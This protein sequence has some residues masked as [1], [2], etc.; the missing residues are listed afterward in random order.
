MLSRHKRAH[1]SQRDD[2]SQKYQRSSPPRTVSA[3]SDRNES[4]DITIGRFDQPDSYD[5]MSQMDD[6]TVQNSVETPVL[7]QS[8][9]WIDSGDM[10]EFLMSDLNWP[11]TLP[12]MQF[13]PSDLQQGFSS[14]VLHPLPSQ[15]TGPGHHAMQQMSKLISDLSSSLT[16]EIESTGITSAFLDT[17]MHV[18]FERFIPSFPVLHK[19]TFSVR[20][21]SHPLLLN[22]IALGSLFVGAKD[23]LAK[24]E[25]LWRL[26]HTAVA[27]SWQ[28]LMATKGPRDSCNGIQLVLT[29]LLGQT[30]AILS[31]N[32]S[33][34]MTSQVFHGLGFYWARQCGM[35]DI[36]E[37]RPSDLPAL[38]ATESQK[39]AAWKTWAAREIQRRA[40]LGHYILDGQIS[41]FSGHSTCA[42]HVINPLLTPA[43]GTAFGA[44]TANAW[45]ME[46][47]KQE[48]TRPCFRE[49]FVSLFSSASPS[50]ERSLS[51]FSLR[52]VLEG[53]QSL[54][55]DVQ[56]VDGPA[57]GTPSK[58]VVARALVRLHN[59]RLSQSD[60]A[61][62]NME[63]LVRWH[64]ICLNLAT[65]TTP[66]CQ[67]LCQFY[68]VQQQLHQLSK[69][70]SSAFDF[71]AWSKSVDGLR[72]LLHAMAIQDL[73]ER[74]PLGRSHAI[75]LPAAIF[76]V[77]TIYSARCIAG[78]PTIIIPKSFRWQDV[79]AID[80][81]DVAN[82][83][84]FRDGDIN[85]FLRNNS[86]SISGETST[87][88]LM[89]DLN[90][91][92]ITLSSISLRWGVSHAMDDVLHRWITIANE[93]GQSNT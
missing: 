42:R 19:A 40:I 10:L 2:E 28:A 76:S 52:V 25:A 26:A 93:T 92:Q 22:I 45:I 72:A 81:S 63:L 68:G 16:A 43:S 3:D 37:F 36:E 15:Q 85:A 41:Q 59:E 91:L 75:H 48:V 60:A 78:F 80:M 51:N 79:W 87:R 70:S 23:A 53:L 1:E 67:N 24:G 47:Q 84:G 58:G 21:S 66:L 88:N 17:C 13:Q 44:K 73:V 8:Q 27:T 77:A 55:S 50:V 89:Y 90:S 9:S 62:E 14:S 32:E 64:A 82:P 33:L 7:E 4:R 56:Q 31:K 29:A 38:D 30:Y 83:D 35:Y 34:R 61:V 11:M 54:A 74:L 6:S 12:V 20:E 5:S 69:P 57:V 46:M 18:F 39:S 86:L 65:P 71:L 49:V